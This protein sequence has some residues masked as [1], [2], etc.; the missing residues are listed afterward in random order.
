MTVLDLRNAKRLFYGATEAKKLYLG[1]TLLW[2]KPP[3]ISDYYG[4]AAG[5]IPMDLDFSKAILHPS[6]TNIK[7]VPNL[8]GSGS[9]HDLTDITT[10]NTSTNYIPLVDG[11]AEFKPSAAMVWKAGYY[12]NMMGTR[13][14]IVA[15]LKGLAVDQFI[16]GNGNPQANVNLRASGGRL[17]INRRNPATNSFET[18]NVNLNPL[19]SGSKRLFEI[20]FSNSGTIKVWVDGQLRG[21]NTHVFPEYLIRWFAAGQN[22]ANGGGMDASVWRVLSVIEGGPNYTSN[23]TAIRNMLLQKYQL[24]G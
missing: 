4:V 23:V 2:S 21:T 3:G 19:V 22:P 13:I 15:D 5:K 16:L 9:I 14:F 17:D 11:K 24:A 12:P 18:C 6:T 20:E 10:T 8:G 7:M 1:S